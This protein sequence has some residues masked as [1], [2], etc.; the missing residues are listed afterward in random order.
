MQT[1]NKFFVVPYFGEGWSYLAFLVIVNG[2]YSGVLRAIFVSNHQW[3][4]KQ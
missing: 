2:F 4:S 3:N 1:N